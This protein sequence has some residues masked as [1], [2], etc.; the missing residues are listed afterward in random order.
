M[1]TP[2]GWSLMCRNHA[3]MCYDGERMLICARVAYDGADGLHGWVVEHA[4]QAER[5]ARHLVQVGGLGAVRRPG[6]VDHR[7]EG[8]QHR[9]Q[10]EVVRRHVRKARLVLPVDLREHG[11]LELAAR[12]DLEHPAGVCVERVHQ[13]ARDAARRAELLQP[14]PY[15]VA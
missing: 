7:A 13:P 2:P 10:A 8:E 14:R 1:V 15:V 5:D 9:E 11:L 12:D 3:M 4:V 6:D